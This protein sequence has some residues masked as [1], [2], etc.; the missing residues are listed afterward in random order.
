MKSAPAQPYLACRRTFANFVG[1][2]GA[3]KEAAQYGARRI[4]KSI[5]EA[6]VVVDHSDFDDENLDLEIGSALLR[7]MLG[8]EKPFVE[9]MG[10]D[11]SFLR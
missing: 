6:L 5:R 4:P 1:A 9:Q 3:L 8:E 11:P 10:L 2:I 7:A